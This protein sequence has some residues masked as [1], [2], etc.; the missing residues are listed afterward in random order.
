MSFESVENN[1][2]DKT[3]FFIDLMNNPK[4][5]EIAQVDDL[6]PSN[7]GKPNE[8]FFYIHFR[9]C[10]TNQI[11]R[12]GFNIRLSDDGKIYIGKG[13]KL[14]PLISFVSHIRDKPINCEKSD[15]DELVGFKFN[16]KSVR[17]KFGAK[18]YFVLIPIEKGGE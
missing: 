8:H 11:V 4:E 7:N 15:I 16:A 13:A 18:S 6:N 9:V 2:I 14:Y 10:E 5:L 3:D 17:R 1:Q 12:I